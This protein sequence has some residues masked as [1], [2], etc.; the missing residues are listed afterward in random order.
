MTRHAVSLRRTMTLSLAIGLIASSIAAAQTPPASPN[1]GAGNELVWSAA[2]A[3][4]VTGRHLIITTKDGLRY[5]GVI[6]VSRTAL[7]TSKGAAVPF[8]QIGR[9]EKP[10]YRM[11]KGAWLGAAAGV[12][13]GMGTACVI[14]D[15]SEG[16]EGI[17]ALGAVYGGIGAGAGAAIGAALNHAR[18]ND[19][20]LYDYYRRTTT[21]AVAPIVSPTRKGVAMKV[22][23][24]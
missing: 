4:S 9:I 2:F 5:E 23:W 16:P 6:N 15:C 19:D 13:I 8:G 24:R 10:T 21:I 1:A 22:T 14:W 11:R 7:E 3:Q 18:R 20:I 12:A 17:L